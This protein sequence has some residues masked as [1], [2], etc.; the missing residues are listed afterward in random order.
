MRLIN[1]EQREV[2]ARRRRCLA[3]VDVL[4]REPEFLDAGRAQVDLGSEL[5]RPLRLA[6]DLEENLPTLIG[7][8]PRPN[9]RFAHHD[10]RRGD[11]QHD[12]LHIEFPHELAT[13]ERLDADGVEVDEILVVHEAIRPIL[14]FE[15][16]RLVSR[17]FADL[18][19][20]SSRNYAARPVKALAVDR[21]TV[22]AIAFDDN[23]APLRAAQVHS[24]RGAKFF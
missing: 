19:Q 15:V 16:D 3:V 4:R 5:D 17:H 22:S 10:G 20:Q 23:E 7:V 8:E 14:L 24:F 21:Q 6:G 9:Q 1:V 13:D 12:A 18:A 11:L 2:P